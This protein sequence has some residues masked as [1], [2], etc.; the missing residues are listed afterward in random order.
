MLSAVQGELSIKVPWSHVNKELQSGYREVSK[1]AK[2]RGFRPGKAPMK[3]VRQMYAKRVQGDVTAHLVELGLLMALQ[4]HELDIVAQPQVTPTPFE[5]DQPLAFTA[6]VE[7]RPKI[8]KLVLKKFNVEK[9]VYE[10]KDDDIDQELQTLRMRNADI[11]IPEPMRAAQANDILTIDYQV[12]VE[13]EKNESLSAEGRE[14]SLGTNDLAEE[15]EAGLLGCKPTDET[16]IEMDCADDH[17]NEELR[18]KKAE[19]KVVVQELRERLLPELDDNFAKDVGDYETL[20]DLRVK[21][22]RT[23]GNAV[24]RS[25][26]SRSQASTC[27]QT[28]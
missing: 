3:I 5:K 12:F 17:P 9:P 10:V 8:E 20:L 16:S 26:R 6:A 4:K 14:V 11:R 2:I 1:H 22:S 13:G 18:G 25:K 28:Y 19:F 15:F 27:R 24:Y 7:V 23:F 21:N